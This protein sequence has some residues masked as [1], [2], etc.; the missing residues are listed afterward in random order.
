MK[1]N[2][3]HNF[4]QKLTNVQLSDADRADIRTSLSEH[5]ADNQPVASPWSQV[6]SPLQAIGSS[7]MVTAMVLISLGGI[8][9]AA[10]NAV[11]GDRLYPV[12]IN[13]NEEFMKL[14]A[15]SPLSEA[16]N[17]SEI[18]S[19][20]IAELETLAARG[21]LDGAVSEQLTDAI[22]EHT[23]LAREQIA[24]I[25]AEGSTGSAASLETELLSTLNT[26]SDIL[27]DLSVTNEGV[28][29]TTTASA[30]AE[31]RRVAEEKTND[32]VSTSVA[33]SQAVPTRSQ[34]DNLSS[35]Q[36]HKLLERAA[37]RL[38]NAR[39]NFEEDHTEFGSQAARESIEE[40]LLASADKIDAAVDN[41]NNKDFSEA[42]P[43]L[44]EALTYAHEASIV[45]DTRRSLETTSG[46]AIEELLDNNAASGT[47]TGG[48]I[49]TGK[50][51]RNAA[52]DS[53]ETNDLHTTEDRNS[54]DTNRVQTATEMKEEKANKQRGTSSTSSTTSTA[55]SSTSTATST[56]TT[57]SS[58]ATT[59]ASS[60]DAT[61]SD[62]EAVSFR[63]QSETNLEMHEKI[64]D[65]LER[66]KKTL[67]VSENQPRPGLLPGR[68]SE[69][70]DGNS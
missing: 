6:L 23:R 67:E 51:Q 24:S 15:L 50:S 25:S 43:L 8:S 21:T 4:I 28:R 65:V 1:N 47:S 48:D 22:S 19:R 36:T 27:Q 70:E 63:R 14:T 41:L 61:S 62:E 38:S 57:S 32:D 49:A 45:I 58:T 40:L 39:A 44:R 60:T 59:T 26:H 2:N 52:D 11:P 68:S 33:R 12:K 31:L 20:R 54:T 35:D 5:M 53:G 42:T 29:A 64:D 30:A 66:V 10:E 69:D 7:A 9:M 34:N 16:E 3:L 13:F 37:D 17:Q 46:I 18:A 56:A 55:S